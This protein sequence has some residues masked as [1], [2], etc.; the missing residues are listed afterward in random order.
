MKSRSR[1]IA[2]GALQGLA[3][4]FVAVG[5]YEVVALGEPEYDLAGHIAVALAGL[6]CGLAIERGW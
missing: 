5:V 6:A 4:V 2:G 1:L 3:I